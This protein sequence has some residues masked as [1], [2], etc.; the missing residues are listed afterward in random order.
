VPDVVILSEAKN[1]SLWCGERRFA[2][3][4]PSVDEGLNGGWFRAGT[5]RFSTIHSPHLSPRRRM[6][7]RLTVYHNPG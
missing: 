7:E 2:E 6:M 4:I 3:F 5:P 1:L